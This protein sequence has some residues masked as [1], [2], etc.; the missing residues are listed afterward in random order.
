MTSHTRKSSGKKAQFFILTTVVIVAVFYSLSSSI[1]PD[2]FIDTSV[3]AYGGEILFFDNVKDKAIKTVEISDSGELE[4][5]LET[6]KD[7]VEEIASDK[8]YSLMFYFTNTT[9]DVK[10]NMILSSRK[11]TLKSNFSIPIS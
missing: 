5:N 11:Y 10:I 3:A 6:Y 4:S 1:N 9:T 7:F 8:G 2:A